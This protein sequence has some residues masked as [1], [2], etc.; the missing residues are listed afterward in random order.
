MKKIGAAIQVVLTWTTAPRGRTRLLNCY[1]IVSDDGGDV[2]TASPPRRARTR[3]VSDVPSA[4]LGS[5]SRR[6]ATI[7]AATL[8]LE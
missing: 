8:P 3:Q 2:A 6:T 1:G 7:V 4:T 5:D